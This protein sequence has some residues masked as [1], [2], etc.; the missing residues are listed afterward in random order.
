[1]TILEQIKKESIVARKAKDAKASAL[2]TTLLSDV[3]MV[4]KNAGRETTDAEAIAIAK[5][6]L[7]N[8]N[9][10]IS[11]ISDS[12]AIADLQNENAI[13]SKFIPVQLTEVEIKEKLTALLAELNIAGPKAMGA[14]LKEFK[15]RYE[16][17]YDGAIASKFA[18]ELLN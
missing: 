7:N 12:E 8:N 11:K 13:L 1:M 16:G 6:F 17:L 4:G 5:K 14:L 9:E 2:L 10:T 3:S 18:K 15:A